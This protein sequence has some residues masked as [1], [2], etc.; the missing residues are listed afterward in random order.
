[1]KKNSTV[2]SYSKKAISILL[3]VFGFCS[4]AYAA[5][6]KTVYSRVNNGAVTDGTAW[7]TSLGGGSCTCTPDFSKD[8]VNINHNT[9]VSGNLDVQSQGTLNIGSNS[10][11]NVS[12]TLTFFNGAVVNVA[13]GSTLNATD[14]VNNNNSNQITVNGAI[15]ATNTFSGGNGSTLTG[16]GS[17]AT[18]GTAI[19]SG[20][21][22]VF[23][24]TT[25]CPVGPCTASN[26][27]QLPVTLVRFEPKKVD[28]SV[29]LT[30]TTGSEI[31][32]DFFAVEKSTDAVNFEVI[33]QILGAGNS[34]HSIEY[35]STDHHTSASRA[36]YRLKQV[37]FDGTIAYSKTVEI[38][39]SKS[40]NVSFSVALSP[41]P[42]SDNLF[43]SFANNGQN[44]LVSV[45]ISELSGKEVF[46]TSYAFGT[47]M[48]TSSINTSSLSAGLYVLS[49]SCNGNSSHQKLV[50]EKRD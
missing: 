25:S 40:E 43:L 34:N 44:G 16:S 5:G 45:S 24:A 49:T 7:S 23:G 14:I 37:D 32:N 9:S 48:G 1:M 11:F 39:N 3:F 13:T 33:D 10:T 18:G 17:L 26:Q 8:V 28:E 22:T 2:K 36:Y 21:G 50:I 47:Q 31:N 20:G 27:A 15:T 42:A 46:S 4:F 12:G 41:N 35:S 29:V 6:S 19:L 38:N 30:W